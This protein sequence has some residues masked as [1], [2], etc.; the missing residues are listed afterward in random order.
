MVTVFVM[1]LESLM[2]SDITE[3]LISNDS[4]VILLPISIYRLSAHRLTV[5]EDGKKAL[6]ALA[7]GDMRK[8]LNVLQSTWLAYK[9]VTEETVYTC[10]GHPQTK[11]ITKIIGWLMN[12]ETFKDC[13]DS[14]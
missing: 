7:G 1:K 8:V 4:H 12:T 13:Y 6:I 9:N 11:D 3:P 5:S 10:V 2:I 14:R